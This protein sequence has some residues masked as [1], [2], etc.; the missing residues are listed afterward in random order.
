M[1]L[2]YLGL[3]RYGWMDGRASIWYV[4]KIR[5]IGVGCLVECLLIFLSLDE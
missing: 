2:I 3:Y 4:L 1:R 5:G